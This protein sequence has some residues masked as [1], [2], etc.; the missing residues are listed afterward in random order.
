MKKQGFTLVELVV[1]I[2]ILGVITLI[3]IPTVKK[4]QESNQKTKYI[5]YAKSLKSATKAFA[6]AYEEDLFGATNSGCATVKYSDLK[7]KE[8]VSDIQIK[9]ITCDDDNET[10]IY[11]MKSKNGNHGYFSN[12]VCRQGTD[13]IYENREDNRS[14]CKIEDGTPPT[15][16]VKFKPQKPKYFIGDD[17]TA[18]ITL[19]DDGI[20]LKANQTLKYE[21]FVN[22]RAVT[23]EKT[24][25]FKNKNYIG[26]VTKSIDM[27]ADLEDIHEETVYVLKVT[28]TVSDVD[29]NT[30][31][32][33]IT[34]ELKYFVG[35][36][37][38]Q[39]KANEAKM[40]NP[41]GARYSIVD[42]YIVRDG[43]DKNITKIKYKEKIGPDGLWNYNNEEYINIRREHYHLDSKKEWKRGSKEYDQSD[44]TY[45]VKDFGFEDEDIKKENKYV[46]VYA[47]W[48]PNTYT[49]TYNNNGGSGCTSKTGTYNSTW[50]TLCTPTRTGYTFSKW[51][52]SSNNTVTSSTKV[53][54]NITVTAQWKVNTYTLTY[55]NDGGSGCSSLQGTYDSVW[56]T[57]CTPT[58]TGYT[59]VKWVD[60]DD[61]NTTITSST[62]VKG[63]RKAKA[64]WEVNTLTIY[65]KPN[66]GTIESRGGKY[67]KDSNGFITVNGVRLNQ[68]INYGG[69]LGDNGLPDNR[70]NNYLMLTKTDYGINADAAW[71][72]KE[73]GSGKSFNQNTV[74]SLEDFEVDISKE[75]KTLTLYANWKKAKKLTA[76]FIYQ[77]YHKYFAGT[78]TT[79][80]C[81][82]YGTGYSC[83]VT[84]PELKTFPS[85]AK[86][87]CGSKYK[88]IIT[89]KGWN[90]NKNATTGTWGGNSISISADT[91]FYS[92][93]V[94][95]EN[96][97]NKEDAF[98]VSA[99]TCNSSYSR[100]VVERKSAGEDD[101]WNPQTNIKE[102]AHFIWTGKWVIK[103][104][105]SSTDHDTGAW[106]YLIGKGDSCRVTFGDHHST[107]CKDNAYIKAFQLKW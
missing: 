92:I 33:N 56:G 18:S 84:S 82:V 50:G 34:K 70:S 7:A 104:N 55:D 8:L 35:A 77:K 73:D 69:K 74:Y 105:Y 51:V 19:A 60:N 68:T 44:N 93:I 25:E 106:L 61:K 52:D 103:S 78:D 96:Y 87:G 59:F 72:K 37:F 36:L 26:K 98:K 75:S 100:N 95:D 10:F 97:V 9:N 65:F 64:I 94:P 83:S 15:A 11:V 38:I 47:N 88:S 54:G 71:N 46:E 62:I 31:P 24:V 13:I 67:G 102:G 49:L 85:T 76:T 2:A 12:I 81:T 101:Y 40:I 91:T 66:G 99:H 20:G 5:A 17:P 1:A 21:W 22:N 39:M 89:R 4:I 23:S 79:E 58:R 45:T 48:I 14:E 43:T 86:S 28:G 3:A 29:N 63:N 27:P 32:I 90:T 6:D 16:I 42:D 41:H 57:L 30:T 80:S 53:T 107:T